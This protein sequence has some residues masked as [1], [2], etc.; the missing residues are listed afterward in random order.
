M[1]PRTLLALAVLLLLGGCVRG[2]PSRRPPIHPNPNMDRQPKYRPQ[3]ASAFFYDGAAM[4]K[5]VPGT[6]ARG[7]LAEDREF[8]SGRNLWGF[9]VMANP[10]TGQP[11]VLA[12]GRERYGI[13]CAPCHGE[14]GDGQGM[15]QER[16][17]VET[18][19]LTEERIRQLPDGR[20]FQV[21]SDGTG[22]MPGY[23]YPIP[24]RDRWAIV[25]HLRQLQA[26]RGSPP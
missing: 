11:G 12:R 1:R 9:P 15:L 16:A 21:I 13:Y 17:K 8:Y 18:A 24:P 19:D 3:A 2:C 23:R 26:G 14:G 20:L 6:V 22:L 7:E 4:Q 25:A 10:L 5:P